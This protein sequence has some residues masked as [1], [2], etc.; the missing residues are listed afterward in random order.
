MVS[1]IDN[2]CVTKDEVLFIYIYFFLNIISA[3]KHVYIY[4]F[5]HTVKE[6]LYIV[7]F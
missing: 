2:D 4:L 1:V 5:V 7:F 6:F 3:C